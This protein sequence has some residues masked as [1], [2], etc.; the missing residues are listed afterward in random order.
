MTIL[1]SLIKIF[2]FPGAAFLCVYSLVLQYL[3]RKLYARL[4]NRQGPPWYQPLA[5]FLKLV[6]QDDVSRYSALFPGVGFHG[7]PLYPHMG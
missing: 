3:D 2:L 4:Q 6:E 5:D 1:L 7:V